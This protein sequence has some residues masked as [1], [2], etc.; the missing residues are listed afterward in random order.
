MI[1]IYEWLGMKKK[2][3]IYFLIS[4][5]I[6]LGIYVFFHMPP[7]EF[8]LGQIVTINSGQSLQAIT[9]TLYEARIIRSPF[10]F[11]TTVIMLGGEKNVWAGD[12]LLDHREGPVDL[13][14]RF[15]YGKFHLDSRKITI[16]EGWNIFQIGD[17]LEKSLINFDKKE[18]L[19]ITKDKEGYLFPDTYFVPPTIKPEGVVTLMNNNFNEKIASTPSIATSTFKLKD[20]IIMASLVELEARTTESR[21]IIAGILWKRLSL[22]MPLQVDSVFLY[23]NGKNTY[24]LTTMDLKIKSPYNTYLYK[25][26]PRGPIGNPGLDALQST[27][28]PTKT[29]YLYFLSSHDGA[30]HYAKTFEEHKRNREKYLNR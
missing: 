4:F 7:K 20:I 8:P 11:R 2:P 9:N 13:A 21:K 29:K 19:T 30:M 15:V 6:L 14:Y 5:V 23:I 16:P 22:G 24:E 3:T 27:V 10:V 1:R 17:Y 25:G 28:D 18:F 26:L 12:Y